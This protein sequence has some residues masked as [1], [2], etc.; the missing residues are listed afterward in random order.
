MMQTLLL[1]LFSLATLGL[2]RWYLRKIICAATFRILSAQMTM[3]LS[4]AIEE[5]ARTNAWTVIAGLRLRFTP[6][7]LL[8][9][10]QEEYARLGIPYVVD[11]PQTSTVPTNS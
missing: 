10:I 7:E 5:Q 8:V 3:P 2:R 1:R 4:E 6:A 11:T 9:L